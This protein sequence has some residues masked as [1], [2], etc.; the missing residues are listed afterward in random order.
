LTCGLVEDGVRFQAGA[1]PVRCGDLPGVLVHV[2]VHGRVLVVAMEV[3]DELPRVGEAAVCPGPPTSAFEKS[4]VS[5]VLGCSTRSRIPQPLLAVM[6]AAGPDGLILLVD[7]TVCRLEVSR[8]RL[9]L[10]PPIED[11]G[12][13]DTSMK[14]AL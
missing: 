3:A 4:R 9:S 7:I 1:R 10:D 5:P 6:V 13:A 11:S 2:E 12:G 14:R 8:G